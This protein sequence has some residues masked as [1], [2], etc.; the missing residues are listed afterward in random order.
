MASTNHDSSNELPQKRKWPRRL[1]ILLAGLM[2]LVYFLPSLILLGPIRQ[3][4]VDWALSDLHGQVQME[5][6]S[7]G[8]FSPIRIRGLELLDENGQVIASVP[9]VTT[10]KRLIDFLRSEQ[11]GRIELAKPTLQIELTREGSNLETALA[12]YLQ[13][14]AD[15]LDS[16]PQLEIDITGGT[17]SLSGPAGHAV[18]KFDAIEANLKIGSGQNSV[19][20]LVSLQTPTNDSGTG[21]LSI[22]CAVGPGKSQ[23]TASTLYAK[24]ESDQF[25]LNAIVPLFDRWSGPIEMQGNLT[26]DLTV[27]IDSLNSHISLDTERL[28][29]EAIRLQAPAYLGSDQISIQRIGASGQLALSPQR[30]TANRF[31]VESDVGK[32]KVDGEF[33]VSQM[34]KLAAQGQL[35]S[36]PFELDAEADLASILQM[37]PE[38]LR[39]RND[40]QVTSG[41]ATLHA[42]TRNQS[43]VQRIMFNLDVA[44][45]RAQQGNQLIAW[46]RPLRL[47]GAAS[48][49]NGQVIIENLS[50]DSGFFELV[51][52]ASLAQ[53]NLTFRGD[54]AELKQQ[55]GNLM[56]LSSYQ[57]AGQIG[58]RLS[59]QENRVASPAGQLAP[60]QFDG[61]FV[62]EQPI[63]SV[64]GVGHWSEPKMQVELN[65]KI[66]PYLSGTASIEA[67]H[68]G[69]LVGSEVLSVDLLQPLS[70]EPIFQPWNDLQ[71]AQENQPFDGL[72]ASCTTT[73]SLDRWLVHLRNLVELPPFDLAGGFNAKYVVQISDGILQIRELTATANRFA[74]A[75]D[76]LQIEEPRVVASGDLDVE[77]ATGR[78]LVRRGSLSSSALALTTNNLSIGGSDDLRLKGPIA[79][80]MDLQRAGNWLGLGQTAGS[81][82]VSGIANGQLDFTEKNKALGGAISARIAQLV[83]RE[84]GPVGAPTSGPRANPMALSPLPEGPSI[85]W[86]ED[87]L[88]FSTNLFVD[89][90]FQSVWFGGLKVDSKLVDLRGNGRIDGIQSQ[91]M[92]NIQ[93][94]WNI[95]WDA[96]SQLIQSRLGPL[97]TIRGAG[98]QDIVIQGP[99]QATDNGSDPWVN[100]QLQAETN[101]AWK[102]AQLLEIP[103]APSH[104]KVSLNDS[105]VQLESD[106][107]GI[108]GNLAKL[109]PRL[110]L[111][112]ADPVLTLQQGVILNDLQ[113]TEEHTR[114]WLKFA[115]PVLADATSADGI[116]GL[117]IQGARVPLL[118]PNQSAARGQVHLK[119]LTIGPGPLTHQLL[120]LV[121]QILMLIKPSIADQS[122]KTKWMTLQEQ[123]VQFA[124]QDERVYHDHLKFNYQGINVETSG[125]VGF[126]Q[127]LDIVASIHIL[128]H[129]IEKEPLLAGL[130]GESIKIPISGTLSQ[131]KLNRQ[132]LAGLSR[133]FL[134]QTA[135]SA[136][137]NV[138]QG[139]LEQAGETL[140]GKVNEEL[141]RLEGQFNRIL[142]EDVG[143]RLEEGWRN[144]LNQLFNR[145]KEK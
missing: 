10:S 73:G 40:V 118:Q 21:K 95:Q 82:A 130:R 109:S 51:G 104:L 141:D 134:K 55:L 125:S 64:P 137:N 41:T 59:W 1:A 138:V 124:V 67:G 115:T 50:V 112:T 52:K 16:L 84:A 126:D 96:I 28:N 77:L 140:G 44:N 3:R 11:L 6:I 79:Y 83:V 90:Q 132:A 99:L 101:I 108:I 143:D 32:L 107:P 81:I 62:V 119:D 47:T 36:S 75:A 31:S 105:V 74:L 98:W 61:N 15:S 22:D 121:D 65:G 14:D 26:G 18:Q 71:P 92:A 25:P 100:R 57:V 38:T 116:I 128:D 93:G 87:E 12:E 106:S 78:V 58:G 4:L 66:Q 39:L 86:Q 45:V 27:R 145:G 144:G 80:Q 136:L 53:G 129:W 120:P 54:L 88:L 117:S 34:I 114:Q 103:I 35:P 2:L 110:D 20:C 7:T 24:L 37:L 111:S 43:D 5:S 97:V 113:L 29:A 23:S 42:N 85:L 91:R 94:K 131:P 56:D 19:H 33:D 123:V 127:T 89:N 68:L 69:L 76:R 139:Q 70:L 122:R 60:L 142:Q 63:L 48:E 30:I 8:W 135:R 133:D 102:Q 13:A 17:L 72:Q 49:N 46:N 9:Q